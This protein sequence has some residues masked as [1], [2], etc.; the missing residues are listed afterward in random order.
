MEAHMRA[1]ARAVGRQLVGR[2]HRQHRQPRQRPSRY[3]LVALQPRQRAE[4]PFSEIW[5]DTCRPDHGR[6]Q[7][8]PPAIK[9]RCGECDYFDIC[10]GNTRTRA[11]Q[12]T[13]DPWEE[14]PGCYL[15]GASSASPASASAS[16]D[17]L[18]ETAHCRGVGPTG[19]ADLVRGAARDGAVPLLMAVSAFAAPDPQAL[20]ATHCASCHGADRLGGMGPRC[21]PKISSA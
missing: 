9:G 19:D 11:R 17:A 10:G 6:P 12:L 4:R 18:H 14:D 1:E 3:L 13:G 2:E 21:C 15:E 16:G 20:Y 8:E 7:G 5:R